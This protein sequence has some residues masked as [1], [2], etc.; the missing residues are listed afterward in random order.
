MSETTINVKSDGSWSGE[1]EIETIDE[2]AEWV[3]THPGEAEAAIAQGLSVPIEQIESKLVDGRAVFKTTLGPQN[4][5]PENGESTGFEN[6]KVQVD[7]DTLTISIA[8]VVPHRLRNA[9]A[10]GA[11][12]SRDPEGVTKVA[13]RMWSVR[14]VVKCPGEVLRAE[15]LSNAGAT[16]ALFSGKTA[17]FESNLDRAGVATLETECRRT[18]DGSRWWIYAGGLVVC[19]ALLDRRRRNKTRLST[20]S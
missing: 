18:G 3:K 10:D 20:R 13:W 4:I 16:A 17:E 8:T 5:R 19:A 11:S 9:L 6:V 12:A 1:F 2:A 7:K 14:F 15:I